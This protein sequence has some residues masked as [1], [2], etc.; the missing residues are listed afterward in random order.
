MR[1][2]I[3]Y[4]DPGT[5][6]PVLFIFSNAYYVYLNSQ[7]FHAFTNIYIWQYILETSVYPREPEPL[8]ELRDATADH[9]RC[10]YVASSSLLAIAHV[11]DRR[12]LFENDIHITGFLF[13]RAFIAAAPDAGQLIDMLLKLVNAKK[14]IEI[15]VFTGY[16]LL[17]T[18]L[19]IPD[20]GKIIAIDVD[21]KNY[22]IGLPIIRRAGVEHKI[23]FIESQALPVLDKLLEEHENEGSLD[24]AFVDADKGNYKNYHERLMKL[25]KV[26]GVVVYDNT[27]WY[28]T[29]ALPEDLVEELVDGEHKKEMRKHIMELNKYLATDSRVQICVAPLGDGI[30]ICRR[31]Y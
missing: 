14:T 28:G 10:L 19:S 3:R 5:A 4:Q 11:E 8:K 12:E 7:L 15:G 27:L 26:G 24:F 30:T 22:E 25:L 17:L 20:D 13:C 29:V 1:N 23:N 31:I 16:S 6:S 2:C 21:R 18:A 9:P